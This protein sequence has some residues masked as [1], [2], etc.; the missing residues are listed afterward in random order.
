M[1]RVEQVEGFEVP[2]DVVYAALESVIVQR[3][4]SGPE[5]DREGMERTLSHLQRR[6]PIRPRA[7]FRQLGVPCPEVSS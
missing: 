3:L 5:G 7:W 2:S 4:A 1:E 6:A